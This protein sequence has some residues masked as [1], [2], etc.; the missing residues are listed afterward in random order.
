MARAKRYGPTVHIYVPK[1]NDV[2]VMEQ[3][4]SRLV[5]VSVDSVKK[6]AGVATTTTSAVVYR[7]PWSKLS[8]VPRER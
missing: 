3:A 5:V 8:V 4:F 1:L 7:V 6:T 2:V